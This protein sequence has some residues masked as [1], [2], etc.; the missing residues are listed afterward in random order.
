VIDLFFER[1]IE[2][3]ALFVF[4][5]VD[6]YIDLDSQQP[7]GI[8]Q[9]LLEKA[10][11]GNHKSQFIFTSRPKIEYTSNQ[12]LALSVSS[13]S[14]HE[15]DKLFTLRGA[16]WDPTRKAEQLKTVLQ[17]TQGSALHLNLIAT[18]IAKQR[19]TLDDLLTRI[20]N[21]TAPEVEDR[22]LSEIWTTLKDEQK[23]VLRYLAEIPHGEPEQ[24]V[25]SCL[26]HILN[27]N[28]FSKAIKVLKGLNL[29]VAKPSDGAGEIIELHPLVKTFIRKSFHKD[30]QAPIV[31]KII[32][33]LDRMIGRFSG[34]KISGPASVLENW[35]GKI[36]LCVENGRTPLAM[37]TLY[38]IQGALQ[39]RGQV[40]EFLRLAELII[41]NY[42]IVDDPREV[43][44]FD[45]ICESFIGILAVC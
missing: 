4:D 32:N 44:K 12:F 23:D 22:I 20:K 40:E 36:E 2:H 38:D 42:Q 1:I 41:S 39:V 10:L 45:Y 34:S 7:T 31:E 5:N 18:Q 19:A 17:V 24:W 15:A 8:V 28:R 27:Y 25:A 26:S 37:A 30:E 13:L 29:I 35:T 21:G 14:E 33:F 9:S 16:S 6:H 3:N 43:H 11:N